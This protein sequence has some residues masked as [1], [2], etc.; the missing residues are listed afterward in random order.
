M[1]IRKYL[2]GASFDPE[3]IEVMVR[4]FD[5]TRVIL[6]VKSESDPLAEVVAKKVI[7]LAS[8]GITDPVEI[9]RRVVE[10][11]IPR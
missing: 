4:A 10:D 3:T 5:D 2:G 6:N 9:R 8:E 11:T 7:S 1:P